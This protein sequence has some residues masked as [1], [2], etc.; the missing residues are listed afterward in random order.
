MGLSAS[1]GQREKCEAAWVCGTQCLHQ[2]HFRARR[3]SRLFVFLGFC[4][5][6][7]LSSSPFASALEEAAADA[8]EASELTSAVSGFAVEAEDACPLG[9]A[10]SAGPLND[11]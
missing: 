11:V 1:A 5:E 6:L 7:G 9:D 8:V 10:E 3:G 2:G 4:T